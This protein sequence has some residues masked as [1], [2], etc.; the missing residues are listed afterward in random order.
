[1]ESSR[2]VMLC[3]SDYCC[4]VAS[5][6]TSCCS[7]ESLPCMQPECL[8]VAFCCQFPARCLSKFVV[9]MSYITVFARK[10]VDLIVGQMTHSAREHDGEEE[11][12]SLTAGRD[13]QAHG[14][15]KK[16]NNIRDE[17]FRGL[18]KV[19]ITSTLQCCRLALCIANLWHQFQVAFA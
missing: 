7:D 8:K 9:C 6:S 18:M 13:Q 10:G 15:V 17:L 16:K 11:C 2:A 19:C 5:M 14:V 1:M 12:V 3:Q 4:A